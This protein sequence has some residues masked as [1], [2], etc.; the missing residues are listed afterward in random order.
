VGL[1]LE[2]RNLSKQSIVKINFLWEKI[3]PENSENNYNGI[4]LKIVSAVNHNK[5]IRFCNKELLNCSKMI[6]KFAL[7]SN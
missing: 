3:T 6:E 2:A 4:Q 7:E 1:N 5:F